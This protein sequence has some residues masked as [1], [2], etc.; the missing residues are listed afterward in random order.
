MKRNFYKVILCAFVMSTAFVSCNKDDNEVF[1]ELPSVREKERAKELK[2]LL[3]SSEKGWKLTYFTDDSELGGFTFLMRFSESGKVEMV[4]DFNE[5]GYKLQVSDYDIQLRG[6][7]SLV[8][9]TENKLHKLSDPYDSP[10]SQS[11]GFK[12]E[13]QWR[14]Y[15]NS[16]NEIEFRGTKEVSKVIRLV[17]ATDADWAGFEKRQP[18]QAFYNDVNKPIFKTLELRKSNGTVIYDG[19]LGMRSR[20]FDFN[21]SNEDFGEASKGFGFGYTNEGAIISPAITI[22]GK[23]YKEFKWDAAKTELV[24]INDG[25]VKIAI[26]N[27]NNPVS[28]DPGY[29]A[30]VSG[31]T[32]TTMMFFTDDAIMYG[33]GTSDLFLK[34]ITDENGKPLFER[35]QLKFGKDYLE[36]TYEANG[37]Y[38]WYE[39]KVKD[40]NGRISFIDA[41]WLTQP[42]AEII[43]MNEKIFPKEGFFLKKQNY[44]VKYSN[45][46]HT[47]YSGINTLSFDMWEA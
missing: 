22:E 21:N 10:T 44:K 13:F 14:F 40:D 26:R 5:E 33:Q 36:V 30:V 20:F 45:I 31:P 11:L 16:E 37:N 43:E 3:L 23:E 29:K 17:K 28:W 42:P 39:G 4:S 46:V 6:T 47:I 32:N 1:S 25:D 2:E 7:T 18:V 35:I 19:V 38:Y 15:G 12:G 27:A 34:T 8:F 41:E 24:S 9:V